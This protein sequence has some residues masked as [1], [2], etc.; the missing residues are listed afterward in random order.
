M[1]VRCT[2]SREVA[3]PR[4]K[5]NP[6]SGE[7]EREDWLRRGP[8]VRSRPWA[9]EEEL[10]GPGSRIVQQRLLEALEA[11]LAEE[12]SDLARTA[13][14]P[15]SSA[16]CPTQLRNLRLA[17]D[18]DPQHKTSGTIRERVDPARKPLRFLIPLR[19][20]QAA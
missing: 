11:D 6:S 20:T 8:Y 10:F 13:E 14:R 1:G 15:R 7:S 12:E 5:R 9:L 2:L 18:C 4:A 3:V 17:R 16:F 19:L